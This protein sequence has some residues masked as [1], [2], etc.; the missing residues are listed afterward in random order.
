MSALG[1]ESECR[2]DECGAERFS[3]TDLQR[4]GQRRMCWFQRYRLSVLFGERLPKKI[5]D[6]GIEFQTGDAVKRVVEHDNQLTVVLSSEKQ[7]P[8][9]RSD[10]GGALASDR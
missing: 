1:E 2:D 9:D 7:L 3:W 10:C 6:R 8:A 4:H 5:A